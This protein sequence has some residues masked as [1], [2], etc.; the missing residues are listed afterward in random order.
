MR[1]AVRI[2][3]YPRREFEFEREF[4]C[5]I[6][7]KLTLKLKLA[8]I[9][10]MWRSPVAHTAGGRGAAGSNPV[11][12]TSP[13]EA[14]DIVGA[15]AGIRTFPEVLRNWSGLRW[16]GP[17]EKKRSFRDSGMAFFV[18]RRS[19]RVTDQEV[20]TKVIAF[21]FEKDYRSRSWS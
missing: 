5:G 20:M 8:L 11:I 13:A 14:Y 1:S 19:T 9:S 7:S 4:E 15:Q 16:T 3:H 21:S 12:P 10:G 6:V 2:R 17:T 18:G